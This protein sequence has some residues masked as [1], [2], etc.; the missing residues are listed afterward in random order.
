MNE[1]PFIPSA[2]K[3]RPKENL[4]D[5]RRCHGKV[6]YDKKSAM[7]AKNHRWERDHVELRVYPCGDHWHLTSLSPH[8]DERGYKS[9]KRKKDVYSRGKRF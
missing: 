7:T 3:M 6:C 5:P 1:E 9:F 8:M 2:G 4:P